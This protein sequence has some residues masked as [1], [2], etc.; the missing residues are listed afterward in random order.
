LTPVPATD[1]RNELGDTL[2]RA[3]GL[4]LTIGLFSVFVNLLMLTGPLFM[5][6]VYDR[7]IA[8]RSEETLTALFLLVAL[9]YGI[10]GVLDYARGRIAARIGA[11]FQSSLDA[12]VFDVV[13]RRAVV[14]GE[15][16]RPSTAL[17]DLES[18]QK[19]LSSP[20]MFAIFDIPWTPIFIFAIFIF[21]PWLGWLAIAGGLVLVVVTLL[22]QSLSRKPVREAATASAVSDAFAESVRE[23]GEAVQ[24]LGMRPAVLARWRKRRDVALSSQIRAAD[25]SG[26]FSSASKTFRFFLQSAMLALGA[27]LVLQNELTAGA[28]IAGSILLGRG[29]APIEQAIAGWPLLQRA[30]QGWEQLTS[31][32][33]RTPEEAETTPLPKPK[34][35]LEA[36]QITVVPPGEKLA[37]L[38]MLSF[39]LEEGQALGVI[40]PSAAG[41]STLARVLTGIWRPA[42][43]KVRL[44]GAALEQYSHE[45]LGQ[46]IGY[47]PQDVVLFGA[48][49]AENIARLSENPDPE[50]VVAA[51]KKAGAHEMI[52]KLPEGYDTTITPGGGRLSGGQ[53]Q[54]LGLARAMYGDP[55]ILILDEP[56]AN[57]D[58][59]GSE[60]L[61]AAIRQMKS[62]GRSVIIMAHRPAA[63]A[64]CDLI[65]VLEEGM[66]KAFGPRDEVLKAQLRNYS[67]VAGSIGAEG[68][69]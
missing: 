34:A 14:T 2:K 23:A 16:G 56:N 3:R 67:Q 31:L 62:E 29:L 28:M 15:R 25:L 13:L 6:Q 44:D 22:N 24:G 11:R 40:G 33:A 41:K 38:R 8:S 64:E 59:Q 48:T 37:T 69:Q 39:R 17:Q 49:V 32:L 51:A 7:V 1:H 47:L 19:F 68:S 63:I 27:Y 5:L 42:S 30:R 66:R 12:R 9:L 58:A 54:R 65:L 35:I 43:G 4:F 10:M 18:I 55:A 26:S 52:L 46:H 60:A 50:L 36:Q 20:V 61:N 45:A 53:K 57:L 21:H